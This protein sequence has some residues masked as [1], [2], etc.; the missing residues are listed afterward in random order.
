MV[1]VKAPQRVMNAPSHVRRSLARNFPSE[2]I[3]EVR[4]NTEWLQPSSDQEAILDLVGRMLA[5]ASPESGSAS[6]YNRATWVPESPRR[7][8]MTC[9]VAG[10]WRAAAMRAAAAKANEPEHVHK[11]RTVSSVGRFSVFFVPLYAGRRGFSW[12]ARCLL[13]S[14]SAD[15]AV[16]PL[17]E[18][19]DCTSSSASR[20]LSRRRSVHRPV[21]GRASPQTEPRPLEIPGRRHAR[22]RRRLPHPGQSPR[23]CDRFEPRRRSRG[24]PHGGPCDSMP[25]R[26]RPKPS[27]VQARSPNGRR[28]R[29]RPSS[30]RA[31]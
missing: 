26:S 8:S 13:T 6:L 9:A 11:S 16:Q 23:T 31:W 10:D 29:I 12:D 27:G 3:P 2:G 21:R 5:C 22:S 1:G 17:N 14:T 4:S 28:L 18:G 25:Q 24:R 20:V 15:R 19:A 30:V 7:I